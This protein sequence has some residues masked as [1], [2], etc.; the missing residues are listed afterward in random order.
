MC[1]TF[2]NLLDHTTRRA[3]TFEFVRHARAW[4]RPFRVVIRFHREPLCATRSDRAA[5][6]KTA[7]FPLLPPPPILLSLYHPGTHLAS[8]RIGTL[9]H[10]LC[11]EWGGGGGENSGFTQNFFTTPTSYSFTLNTLPH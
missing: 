6:A 10:A 2:S 9:T 5:G 1:A 8:A 4:G 3:R 11:G 7:R